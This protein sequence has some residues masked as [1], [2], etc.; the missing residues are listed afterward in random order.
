MRELLP[1]LKLIRGSLLRTLLL[2]LLLSC[3]ASLAAIG[4][5]GLSGWFITMSALVG[6]FGSTSFSYFFPSAGVRAF[7]LFRTVGRYG[8]RTV[9]HQATFLFLARL[10]VGS[11]Q[12]RHTTQVQ[13][14]HSSMRR[15]LVV[16]KTM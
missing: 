12:D 8:E 7:A 1:S 5:L 9:N 14:T 10:R 3:V 2:G 6:I 15:W 13:A 4:L 11:Q 16:E